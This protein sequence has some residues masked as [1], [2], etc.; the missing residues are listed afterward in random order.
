[1]DDTNTAAAKRPQPAL[2]RKAPNGAEPAGAADRAP[3]HVCHHLPPRRRQDHADREAAAVRRRHSARRPGQGQARRPQHPLGLDGHRAGARHLRRHLGDD[4]RVRRRRLQP[5][6]HAGPRG[7]LRPY[8]SH[9]DGGGLGDHG[10]RRRAGASR[11]ARASCSRSAACATSPSS[12]SSTRWIARAA[13]RWSC[14][15]RSST[16]WR[17]RRHPWS[18]PSARAATSRAPTISPNRASVR[19]NRSRRASPSP[20]RTTPYSTSC[21]MQMAPRPRGAT[22][23]RWLKPRAASSIWRSSATARSRPYTS[24]ARSRISACATSWRR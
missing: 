4:V 20:V 11:R 21:W 17:C 10:D 7:L 19:W 22:R 3:A 24:A 18:G 5:A 12:P 23:S 2:A 9:A 13:S 8:L 16:R 6:G 14:S 1:M 15:T